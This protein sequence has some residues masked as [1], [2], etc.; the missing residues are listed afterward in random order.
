MLKRKD[1]MDDVI[2]GLSLLQFYLRYSSNRLGLHDI[3]KVCEPFF[4]ELFNILWNKGYQRLEGEKKNHPG[5]DLGD[6]TNKSSVQ[7]TSDGTKQK[8]WGTIDQFEDNKLYVYYNELIHFVV[9]EKD[10]KL[11]QK[12]RVKFEKD[13]C[14]TYITHRTIDDYEYSIRIIDLM[15][16]IEFIDQLVGEEFS[17]IHDYIKNHIG[18]P[19]KLLMNNLYDIDPDELK[20]FTAES[21]L[22][23]CEPESIDE[24]N[25]FFLEIKNLANQI[26]DMSENSKRFLY[27][28]LVIHQKN[29]QKRFDSV[30]INPLVIQK[31]L[32]LSNCGMEGEIAVL[33][34]AGLL[35]EIAFDDQMLGVD[36]YEKNGHFDYIATILTYCKEKEID[37]K[38]LIL[39][40][41]FSLLD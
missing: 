28:I 22:D 31:S 15:D 41:D 1:E 36:Y 4:C 2:K 19:V 37:L 23:F 40:P 10:Y 27:K 39:T 13:I 30:Q 32:G 25:N 24:R 9:G 11:K 29:S 20:A 21:F 35:D 34:N 17:N 14:G 38:R 18:D 12:D 26:N 5:I 6:K 8:L 16:L 3:N 33:R 7:I